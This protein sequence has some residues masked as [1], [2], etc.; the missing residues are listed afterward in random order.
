MRLL[1]RSIGPLLFFTFGF[2]LLTIPGGW[3]KR[4]NFVF[5]V[6]DHQHFISASQ[7]PKA[8]WG[9]IIPSMFVGVLLVAFSIQLA[10]R[11]FRTPASQVPRPTGPRIGLAIVALFFVFAIIG[12]TVQFL[13]Q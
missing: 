8:F 3:I 9:Y 4:G 7:T 6:Q 1:D 12:L 5:T 13:K 2:A 10:V 11:L